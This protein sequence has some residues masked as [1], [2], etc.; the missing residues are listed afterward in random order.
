MSEH[1]TI[2]AQPPAP[3]TDARVAVAIATGY[4][5]AAALAAAA[6]NALCDAAEAAL[7]ADDVE[8]AGNIALAAASAKRSATARAV[9]AARAVAVAIDASARISPTTTF[10]AGMVPAETTPHT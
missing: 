7:N 4:I 5:A 10:S 8:D 1:I 2:D 6:L 9:A 3:A